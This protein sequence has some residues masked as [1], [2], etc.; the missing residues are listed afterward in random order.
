MTASYTIMVKLI[1]GMAGT[2]KSTYVYNQIVK[3][4]ENNK[5]VLLLTPEQQAVLS[6]RAIAERTKEKNVSTLELEILSFRRLA[7]HVFRMYGGLCYR[8]LE[9]SGKYLVLW[10]TLSSIS[11]R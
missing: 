9:D 6:E 2:G 10:A 1:Y 8:Y 11:S 4:L 5:R 7:N 3:D